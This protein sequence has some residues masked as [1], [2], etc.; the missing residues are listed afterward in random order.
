MSKK[1]K[2][3]LA[4]NTVSS[5]IAIYIGLFVNLYLWEQ[6]HSIAELSLYNL[7]MFIS[8]GIA[9]TATAK[10][11]TRFTIRL[12]LGVSA[13]CGGIAFAYLQ[14]AHLEPRWAWIVILG[15]PIGAMF[16]FSTAAQNLSIALSGKSSELSPYFAAVSIIGQ[17]LSIAV[18]FAAAQVIN[19]FGYGGSFALM[20][21]FL[22][23]MLVFSAFIPRMKLPAPQGEA[24]RAD[25]G[26]FRF[27]L[28]FGQPGAKWMLL[29][30][31]A[32]GIFLQFQNLFTLLFTFSVTE[33]KV[34]IALLNMLYTLS[35]VGG[36]WV[37]RKYRI[38][39]IRWLWMGAGLLAVGFVIVL[40]RHPAALVVSNVLT[41][42]GMFYF[43][44]VW[45]AQQ[46]RFIQP[47]GAIRQTSFLV[48]RENILVATRCLL[49]VLTFQLTE[50]HGVWFVMIISFTVCCLMLI[51]LFQ[52]LA[53]R[54]R[55]E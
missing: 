23:L 20:L 53:L 40:F 41:A 34:L 9:F 42:V 1:M 3:L 7:S 48:W 19:G 38:H 26:K 43:T 13:V 28:A 21:V 6:T 29:S 32:A 50:L 54:G 4:M 37:Y 39:E 55:E 31:L 15:I 14:Y 5:I 24:E 11:L 8:W 46:F 2:K 17:V 16:G 49:L 25:H 44:T 33:N 52:H 12:P 27:R 36:L 30:M 18:P 47:A 45:N 35:A 22:V 10:L 51:P